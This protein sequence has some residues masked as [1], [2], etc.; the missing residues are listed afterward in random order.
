MTMNT[1]RCVIPRY[2]R[3]KY[4][5]SFLFDRTLNWIEE[6]LKNMFFF[7]EYFEDDENLT[8]Y[9][10]STTILIFLFHTHILFILNLM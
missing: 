9:T 8:L 10:V 3:I 1:S 7:N 5:M 6:R 4:K 2:V